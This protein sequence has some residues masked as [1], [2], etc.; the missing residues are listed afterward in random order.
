MV[1]L[2]L[3]SASHVLKADGKNNPKTKVAYT[4]H[5][6][7]I[8]HRGGQRIWDPLTQTG[9]VLLQTEGSRPEIKTLKVWKTKGTSI[10]LPGTHCRYESSGYRPWEDGVRK[11]MGGS[12]ELE[13]I[14]GFLGTTGCYNL[15][16]KQYS[17]IAKP[18]Y[19]LSCKGFPRDLGTNDQEAFQS[20]KNSLKNHPY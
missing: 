4:T 13:I 11:T 18:L 1:P 10:P 6:P 12:S 8:H 17:T 7:R 3:F 2:G 16:I 5:V 9:S 20:L 14:A 19:V 15:Y